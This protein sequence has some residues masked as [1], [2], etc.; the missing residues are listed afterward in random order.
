MKAVWKRALAVA[1]GA[2]LV[3]LSAPIASAAATTTT[4]PSATAVWTLTNGCVETQIVV[5]SSQS[6]SATGG[7][8]A[9][10]FF[11]LTQQQTCDDPNV[12]QPVLDISGLFTGGQLQVPENLRSGSLLATGPVTC[13]PYAVGACDQVPYNAGSVSLNLTW[14]TRGKIT[15]TTDGDQT[16]RYRYGQATGSILLGSVDLVGAGAIPS[17]PTETNVRLCEPG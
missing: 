5:D 3:M 13:D 1:L 15:T 8:V 11:F 4:Q 12:A 16:C 6:L 10:N 7:A 9:Q 14:V 2:C 17:D